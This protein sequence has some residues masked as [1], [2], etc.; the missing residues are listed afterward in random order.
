MVTLDQWDGKKVFVLEEASTVE[1]N[2]IF[3]SR[4]FDVFIQSGSRLDYSNFNV[5]FGFLFF[6]NEKK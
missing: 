2:W 5:D 4:K 3:C 6:K 1:W